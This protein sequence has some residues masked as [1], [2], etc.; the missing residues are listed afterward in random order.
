[1]T[2][3]GRSFLTR[4]MEINIWRAPTDNDRNIKHKWF[5]AHYNRSMPRAYST[6]YRAEGGQ[7]EIKSVMSLVSLS[8]QKC[9]DIEAVW[10]V[11][12]GGE[13]TVKLAVKRDKKFPELPRFGLRLFLPEEMDKVTFYGMGPGESYRDKCRASRHGLFVNQVDELHEDYIRPQ[14]NGSHYDCDYVKV[15]SASCSLTAVGEN[16][17]SFNAS[18]FTQEELTEKMHNYELKPCGST[19]LCLDYAQNG[20]GSNSC[21][22]GVLKKYRLDEEEFIFSIKL[23]VR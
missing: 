3:N 1:M 4:P 6:G 22:P 15:E 18:R 17:F 5:G 9:M 23:I 16:T 19:V 13:V 20:I 11:G 10:T 21:G 7:V 12:A 2:F 8:I 14:E